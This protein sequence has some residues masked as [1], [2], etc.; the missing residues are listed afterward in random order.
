MHEKTTRT[1]S[2]PMSIWTCTTDGDDMPIETA[3]DTSYEAVAEPCRIAL[4]EMEWDGEMTTA[5]EIREAW[6]QVFGGYCVIEMHT[7]P[8][9]R[10]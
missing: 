10:A 8:G 1:D 6:A 7:L 4:R 5:E 2:T 9:H 3:V